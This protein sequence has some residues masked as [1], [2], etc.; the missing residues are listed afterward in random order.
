MRTSLCKQS[1]SL[2]VCLLLFVGQRVVAQNTDLVVA[3]LNL[4]KAE[5]FWNP[6]VDQSDLIR[7]ERAEHPESGD[8]HGGWYL[9]V[10]FPQH[11]SPPQ[12]FLVQFS[13]YIEKDPFHPMYST[14]RDDE[15]IN[16]KYLKPLS[17]KVTQNGSINYAIGEG[18]ENL[19]TT[20]RLDRYRMNWKPF[21]IYAPWELFHLYELFDT[22]EKQ[23]LDG[24]RIAI[25][26]KAEIFINGRLVGYSHNVPRVYHIHEIPT[27][28]VK[29]E[30][31]GTDDITRLFDEEPPRPPY[32]PGYNPPTQEDTI[33][34]IPREPRDSIIGYPPPPPPP[35]V[36]SYVTSYSFGTPREVKVQ[37]PVQFAFP[38]FV[39]MSYGNSSF[40]FAKINSDLGDNIYIGRFYL[41]VKTIADAEKTVAHLND[42]L[43]SVGAGMVF[44][45]ATKKEFYDTVVNSPYKGKEDDLEPFF[46]PEYGLI[47]ALEY[48]KDRNGTV[49]VPD[50]VTV[51]ETQIQRC[52]CG[53]KRGPYTIERQFK[54]MLQ[55]QTYIRR[56]M[57]GH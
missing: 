51:M 35:H 40:N 26:I 21:E 9:K 2:I 50:H 34:S 48:N 25:Y 4:S 56:K 18:T 24:F 20:T 41:D 44:R 28:G 36:H 1:L 39:P 23:A 55:C 22:P 17:F 6:T 11:P 15:V 10:S 8:G 14:S 54:S 37:K 19:K 13:F 3:Q 42:S 43:K 49:V 57:D 45:L 38:D 52:A 47:L 30:Y 33:P 7:K 53:E 46:N 29:S 5:N 27:S 31:L 12:E 32:D 16:F